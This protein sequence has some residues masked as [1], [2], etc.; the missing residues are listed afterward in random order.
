ML[1]GDCIFKVDISR[2]LM[3][4]YRRDM[5]SYR[6]LSDWMVE[7]NWD[8]FILCCSSRLIGTWVCEA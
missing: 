7:G 8:M 4:Q 6:F 2:A 1:E 3:V 5:S